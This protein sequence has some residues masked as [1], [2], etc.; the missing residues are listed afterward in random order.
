MKK[1]AI[2]VHSGGMDSSLSLAV[3]KK[4]YG[5]ENILSMTF[6]YNQR[7]IDEIERAR[8]I[9]QEWNIDQVILDISCLAAITENAL[10]NKNLEIEYNSNNTKNTSSSS[11]VRSVP[12]TLVVGRNGLMCRI[13]AIHAN[14]LGAKKVY[15]GVI[16]VE[17]ANSGYR[18]CTRAYMDKMQD[19][20]RIDLDD[21]EFEV[22]TPL[23]HMTKKETMELGYSLGEDTLEFL[24]ENTITCYRGI[25]KAGCMNCPACKLRNQGILQFI[26]EHPEFKLSYSDRIS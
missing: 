15:M 5:P 24:L 7:H 17:A 23:V 14:H 9:C 2:I 25:D 10:T 12:N 20:L 4:E 16:G 19:I 21:P 26:N 1:K 13:A 18:D 22:V 8:F 3:A 6:T 11:S